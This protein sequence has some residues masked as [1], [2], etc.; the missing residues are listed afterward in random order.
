[1][2]MT[3]AQRSSGFLGQYEWKTVLLFVASLVMSGASFYTTYYGMIEFMGVK[4]VAAAITFSVQALLFV[5]SWW[6]ARNWVLGAV[7]FIAGTSIFL[8]CASISVFFSFA[9]LF[10]FIDQGRTKEMTGERTKL[11]VSQIL[12]DLDRTLESQLQ[13]RQ[14]AFVTASGQTYQT[15]RA[16]LKELLEVAVSAPD[17]YRRQQREQRNK[18]NAER[19]TIS[20]RIA[21]VK[22]QLQALA[23]D[24]SNRQSQ[25]TAQKTQIAREERR[26]TALREQITEL[27]TRDLEL[28]RTKQKEA[29]T[30]IGP[31]YRTADTEQR[32]VQAELSFVED[33][34]QE[35]LTNVENLRN[36]ATV[37]PTAS[38]DTRR[39]DLEQTIANL[40]TQREEVD[41]LITRI[42]ESGSFD[43]RD[44]VDLV[45]RNLQLFETSLD[46]GAFDQ[47]VA[48]CK[49]MRETLDQFANN[50]V[51]QG[52]EI[53]QGFECARQRLINEVG[54]LK[55]ASAEFAEFRQEC[56][57]TDVSASEGDFQSLIRT[58]ETCIAKSRLEPSETREASE[59]LLR[60]RTTGD[61][62]AHG[63]ALAQAALMR[64]GSSLA[65]MALVIAIA[66]DSLVLLCAMIG[67]SQLTPVGSDIDAFLSLPAQRP[68]GAED[69]GR[70]LQPQGGRSASSFDRVTRWLVAHD[71]AFWEHPQEPDEKSVLVLVSG[72]RET[73]RSVS[74]SSVK[75][76]A[77][78]GAAHAA[79]AAAQ[80]RNVRRDGGRSIRV[81]R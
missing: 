39:A 7:P 77:G 25:A 47:V 61:D 66:I 51:P 40:E 68:A 28:E 55:Q 16:Q 45:D 26:I 59:S 22:D 12:N 17:Q 32:E 18:L 63:F 27:E 76:A 56:V 31:A 21:D 60:L 74:S 42:D 30:G 78:A 53:P 41:T 67:T 23:S 69:D 13:E 44:R 49:A 48:E 8:L 64:D 79:S 24:A 35:R 29:V 46:F 50:G 70:Y 9:S 62:N 38:L 3:T 65:M 57:G 1:M 10:S 5:I 19:S 15:W 75:V 81:V 11:Q 52:S 2:T 14:K 72:A 36:D 20:S 58:G 73:L 4:V 37:V 54:A 71:L 80:R 6:L 43:V 34:L 33:K